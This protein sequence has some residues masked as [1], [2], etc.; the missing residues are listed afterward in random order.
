MG[1]KIASAVKQ[2]INKSLLQ[3]GKCEKKIPTKFDILAL[4][5]SFNYLKKIFWSRQREVKGKKKK[6]CLT[7]DPLG[8][9]TFSHTYE[10]G[11]TGGGCRGGCG[12]CGGCGGGGDGEE[13]EEEIVHPPPR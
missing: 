6:G 9:A 10:I 2:L 8:G 1:L 7:A 13:D 5:M 4:Q 12:G 3:K 11:A